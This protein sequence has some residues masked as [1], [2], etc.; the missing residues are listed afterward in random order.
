MTNLLRLG[1]ASGGLGTL[2]LSSGNVTS[3]NDVLVGGAVG[4]TGILHVTGIQPVLTVVDDFIMADFT[5]AEFKVTLVNNRIAPVEAGDAVE[6]HGTLTV[7]NTGP[8]SAGEYIIATSATDNVSGVFDVTNWNGDATGTV[9]YTAD[10]VRIS[11]RP[12]IGVLGTNVTQVIDSGDTSPTTA[13]GT[14]FSNVIA[15]DTKTHT[16]TITNYDANVALDLTGA[17]LVDITGTHSA[18]FTV[19]DDPSD[20]IAGG[21]STTFDV[22]FDPS[23]IGVHT[24]EVSIAHNDITGSE[25]PYT[26]R[27][28]GTGTYDVEPT[29][30]ASNLVF[31]T[32]SNRQMNVSW[33]NGDGAKRLLVA[34]HTDA[35]A[36]APDD[37][38]NYV[39]DAGFL[40]GDP[41]GT[42]Y[43]VYNDSGDNETVTNLT[44][45]ETYCFAVYEYN[46]SSIAVNYLTNSVLKGCQATATYPAVI[47]EGETLNTNV[48]ENTTLSFD[49]H[50]T[51]VD[52]P[53]DS[54]TWSLAS[55]ASHG[56]AGASGSGLTGS[57]T[58]T[59]ALYF[60]GTDSFAVRITDN[61]SNT[62]TITVNVTVNP[63]NT[64]GK[65]LFIFE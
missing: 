55:A 49:L 20:P 22:E 28:T 32:I 39:A 36:D 41:I 24:A 38:S 51:D 35:V 54:H 34:R 25:A 7:S 43:T 11:F 18:N 62:D 14:D 3:H 63:V 13:D 5:N 2:N 61:F 44:P 65:L 56:T 50:A 53:D 30:N 33:D 42:G 57:V 10:M 8:L 27:L 12:E 64:P 31:S 46:G 58:Y 15:T 23:F 60:A 19:T 40:L 52:L 21:A 6:V 48:N 26:F 1:N 17:P 37:G 9:Y 29:A 16:F 4:S 47:T 59:P 45:G